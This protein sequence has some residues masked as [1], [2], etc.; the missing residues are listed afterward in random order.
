MFCCII[1]YHDQEDHKQT[2]MIPLTKASWNMKSLH[3][4][5]IQNKSHD[6]QKNLTSIFNNNAVDPSGGDS[7]ESYLDNNN[8]PINGPVVSAYADD[9]D[10]PMVNV[11][12]SQV[13]W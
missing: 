13:S 2:W 1:F 10:A 5:L 12:S 11:D 3:L 8:V 6:L 9:I 4:H 7:D